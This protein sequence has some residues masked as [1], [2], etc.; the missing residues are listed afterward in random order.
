MLSNEK[1]IKLQSTRFYVL[2]TVHTK[3]RI[4]LLDA[5]KQNVRARRGIQCHTTS[6]ELWSLGCDALATDRIVRVD[7]GGDSTH[8]GLFLQIPYKP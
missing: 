1:V 4:S 6:S 5:P 8:P 7:V 3:S 2:R